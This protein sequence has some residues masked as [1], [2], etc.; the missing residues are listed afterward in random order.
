MS[1]PP[2]H[3]W[4]ARNAIERQHRAL[5]R[6]RSKECARLAARVRVKANFI[7][8]TAAEQGVEIRLVRGP[9]GAD[10]LVHAPRA[11]DLKRCV[12]CEVSFRNAVIRSLEEFARLIRH[13]EGEPR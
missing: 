6:L 2:G 5:A 7:A 9:I 3:V 4:R 11:P 10:V 13:E 1:R 8:Q 12:D